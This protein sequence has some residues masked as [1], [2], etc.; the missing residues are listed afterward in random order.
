MTLLRRHPVLALAFVVALGLTMAFATRFVMQVI[1]WSNPA[2]HQQPVEGWMTPGYIGRS[3]SL[4]AR[5][6]EAVAGLPPRVAG[7]P[8]T[9]DQIAEATGQPVAELIARVEAALVDLRARQTGAGAP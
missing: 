8:Q 3:W 6:I 2:H 9:L 7:Q 1:Y 4:S 5:E